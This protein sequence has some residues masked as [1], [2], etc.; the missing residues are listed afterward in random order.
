MITLDASL[1]A[2][3]IGIL[4]L[5]AILDSFLYKPM[6]RM[7]QERASKMNSIREEAERYERNAE[8]LLESFNAKQAKA[9][10]EGIQKREEL[11]AQAREE[12]KALIEESTKEALEEKNTLLSQLS[13]QIETAR[14]ELKAQAE[15]FAME[16]AQKLLGRAL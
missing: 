15:A 6:R 5:I 16:I 9:R 4:I 2:Q 11:K 12:E 14:N 8:Q 10:S 13:T 7:L 3:V 1:W